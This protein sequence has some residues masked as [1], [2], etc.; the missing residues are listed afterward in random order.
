MSK[1]NSFL[2]SVVDGFYQGYHNGR[3]SLAETF[4]QFRTGHTTIDHSRRDSFDVY[5]DQNLP[6]DYDYYNDYYDN[7]VSSEVEE[8]SNER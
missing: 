7:F 8:Y 3:E 1:S 4:E 2:G 5:E 6:D